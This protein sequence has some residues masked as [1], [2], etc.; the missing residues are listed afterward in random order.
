MLAHR[1]N[2]L[3]ADR[4]FV[5]PSQ[6]SDVYRLAANLREND[7]IEVAGFGLDPRA[8]IRASYRH[9]ILRRTAFVDGEIAAMWGLGGNMLSDEGAPWLMTA[10]VCERVPV[11]F[12]KVGRYHLAEMLR[13]RRRLSNLVAASYH[14]AIRFLEV[15]G[16]HLDP[17]MRLTPDG[18]PFHRFWIE[19]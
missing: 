16:F 18:P 3:A 13:H 6:V 9:A 2:E 10:P 1:R 8:A 11:T 15:L 7:R 12:V 14:Q 4:V 5:R 19:R 17:P